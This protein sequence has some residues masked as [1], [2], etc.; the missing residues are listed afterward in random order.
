MSKIFLDT[1]TLIEIRQVGL[2]ALPLGHE[3]VV[4]DYIWRYEID[5]PM[6]QY[7]SELAESSGVSLIEE[8]VRSRLDLTN[9]AVAEQYGVEPPRLDETATS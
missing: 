9:P 7:I 2:S 3:Y 5:E 8:D 1:G 6:R 4:P